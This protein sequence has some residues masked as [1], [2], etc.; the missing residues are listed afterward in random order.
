MRSRAC[1][2]ALVA[3]MSFVLA[4]CGDDQERT[5]VST[6]A[7]LRAVPTVSGAERAF[8]DELRLV[9]FVRSTN[10]EL[11]AADPEEVYPDELQAREALRRWGDQGADLIVTFSSA[12]ALLANEV[13]PTAEVLFISNDPVAAGLVE[14]EARPGGRMTGVA[15][16]VPA[17]RLLDAVARI[18]PALDRVGLAYPADDTAAAA[19][20]DLYEA[21]ASLLGI[22]VVGVAFDGP[23]ELE[24]SVADIAAAGADVLALSASPAMSRLIDEAQ[25]AAAAHDLPVISTTSQ[26]TFALVSLSPDGT[27]VGRQL[28]RQAARILGG[29]RA[30]EVPVETPRRFVLTVNV[31]VAQE[32]GFEV[33]DELITEAQRVIP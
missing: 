27:E 21:A 7:F 28:G 16:R 9:G 10:L 11:L 17:D 4:A 26:A 6:V 3:A 20:R 5:D 2:A 1:R 30:A 24:R 13:V 32:F 8:V 12:G 25:T 15:Y 19:N 22:E 23:D 14:D 31:G 33:P 29:A 18:V